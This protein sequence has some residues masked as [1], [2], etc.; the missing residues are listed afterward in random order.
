[1]IGKLTSEFAFLEGNLDTNIEIRCRLIGY[2]TQEAPRAQDQRRCKVTSILWL[3]AQQFLVQKLDELWG[4]ILVDQAKILTDCYG[5]DLYRRMLLDIHAVY[6]A[7]AD[8][9][10]ATTLTKQTLRWLE[11]AEAICNGFAFPTD[12]YLATITCGRPLGKLDDKKGG[13]DSNFPFV[14]PSKCRKERCTIKLCLQGMVT[15]T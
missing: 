7:E 6:D 13:F 5:V 10:H 11:M 3:Q 4:E 8:E 9:Q 2:D 1:M 15:T 12:H 14:H